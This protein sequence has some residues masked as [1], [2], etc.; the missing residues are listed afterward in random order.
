M[1]QEPKM[2]WVCAFYFAPKVINGRNVVELKVFVRCNEFY[3]LQNCFV[4]GMC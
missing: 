3:F 4:K 2:C 1:R